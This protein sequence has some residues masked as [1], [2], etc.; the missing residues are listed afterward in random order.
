M[1]NRVCAT[2]ASMIFSGPFS[3]MASC[4]M[5]CTIGQPT[6]HTHPHL[7][8]AGELTPGFTSEE[9]AKRRQNLAEK[10]PP[11]SVALLAAALPA[12]IASTHIPYPG[13]RQDADFAY[14]TGI[15]Q[16]N[17][18]AMIERRSGGLHYTLFSLRDAP[19]MSFGTVGS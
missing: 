3:L 5:M 17:A 15:L 2:R 13:Y 16:P 1:T 9:Y 19:E 12:H 10:L 14:L 4:K 18:S 7:M 6:F 11:N 8:S